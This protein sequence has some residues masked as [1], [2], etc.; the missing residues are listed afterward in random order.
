MTGKTKLELWGEGMWFPHFSLK[1][2]I[3][4]NFNKNMAEPINTPSLS[5]DSD[6]TDTADSQQTTVIP[7]KHLSCKSHE[8][9][10]ANQIYAFSQTGLTEV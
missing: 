2:I 7:A 10:N 1:D 8:L 5:P 4:G 6:F 3:E 9:L